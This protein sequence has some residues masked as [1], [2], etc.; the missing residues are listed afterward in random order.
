MGE[1][2]PTSGDCLVSMGY[3]EVIH[4]RVATHIRRL[5]CLC[6]LPGGDS[7]AS[8]NTHQETVLSLWVTWR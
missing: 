4:G 2:Q 5:S 1:L 6:G 7:W 8:C 3:L